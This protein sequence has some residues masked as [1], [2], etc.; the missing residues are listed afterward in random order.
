IVADLHIHSPYSL[1]SASRNSPAHLDRWARIKGI[2]LVGTG[3]CTHPQW[4]ADLRESLVEAGEGLYAL[5]PGARRDFDRLI[6]PA[7]GLPCPAEGS[8]LSPRFVLTGEISTVYRRDGRTR[9]VHHLILLPGLEAA[10]AFQARLER[11]GNIRSD[12]RP[13]LGL[14]SRD[15]LEM[16][17]ESDSRAQ[18]I[19][20]HIWTPWFSVMGERSG[21]DSIDECYRDLAPHVHAIETGLS[22]NPPMNW[23]LGCLDRFAII[24]NSDAHSPNRLGREATILEMEPSYSSLTEALSGDF[25]GTGRTTEAGPSILETVE[26]FPQEGKYHH[27]GHRKCGF[28]RS[29]VEG[30]AAGSLCPVCG[31][32]LT[33]GVLGRVLQLADRP[34][35]ENAACPP[36][37]TAR[38]NRRPYRSLIPL[39][40]LLGEIL[41]VG[42]ASKKVARAYAA[43]VEKAG[44]EFAVLMQ[45]SAADLAR[46]DCPGVSGELLSAAVDRMRKGEVSISPGYDGKYGVVRA[47][48]VKTDARADFRG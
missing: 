9:K 36:Q 2:N 48:P 30:V 18:L 19:P 24:S 27:D 45:H 7:E 15:L 28:S 20:A 5:N 40:E 42:T 10:A 14:D 46:L 47:L 8:G 16:L 33:P 44:G 37:T 38:G 22:S 13:V 1:A 43:L 6:A 11:A 41:G 39:A 23:A 32:P 21:F 4:L 3:D 29:P 35:D 25:A 17:L 31:K 26:F 34:V 12:G